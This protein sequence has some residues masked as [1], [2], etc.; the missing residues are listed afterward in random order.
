MDMLFWATFCESMGLMVLK[1]N[2]Q[3]FCYQGGDIWLA[4]WTLLILQKQN[5]QKTNKQTNIKQKNP[6]YLKYTYVP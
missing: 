2:R 1:F 3:S 6:N 5:K 4:P